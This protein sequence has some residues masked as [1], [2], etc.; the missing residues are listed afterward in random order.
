M[1]MNSNQY[2]RYS[3]QI[4]LK[5][6]GESAQLKL[7]NAKILMIG[8]G[9]LGCPILQYL[10]AVGI[11][12][13]GIVDDDI[14][15]LSNLHRQILFTTTDIGLPKATCAASV[16]QQ[17]NPDITIN[18]YNF[19]LSNTNALELISEYDIIIDGTDNFAS[20]YLIN[21]ACVLKNKPLIYGSIYQFE[22]QVAVFNV[23][24]ENQ[25]GVSANYR[26]L[27]P[28][29]PDENEILS[30]N[31]AGVIGI[32]PGIIGMMMANECIKL[33]T[34]IGTPLINKLSIY[35]SLNNEIVE[36]AITATTESNKLIPVNEEEFKAKEY[37]ILCSTEHSFIEIDVEEFNNL[38]NKNNTI[39][40]DVRE[41]GEIPLVTSFQ[42]INIPMSLL[43]QEIL[44]VNKENILLFCNSGV[45]SAKAASFLSNG[46]NKVYSLKGGIV[47]WT[48]YHENKTNH[49]R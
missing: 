29:Q 39:V 37:S 28:Q 23:P 1:E 25:K 41:K 45:R 2:E 9:G 38:R 12:T 32:L 3:R 15:S 36:M 27:F 17:L 6:F 19:R 33:I 44:N 31:E 18:K 35:N 5:Q 20:R 42:H 8:A 43:P 46:T 49:A 16:L 48:A 22:G 14:V 47:K 10:T 34:K 24:G 4:L 30:C 13:I 26:D 40:I 11:G 21:D 7:L